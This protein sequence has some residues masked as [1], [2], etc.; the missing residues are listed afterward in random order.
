MLKP[1]H[2]L[3]EIKE[4][5]TDIESNNI[6]RLYQQRLKDIENMCLSDFVSKF[7][8][9]YKA[10]KTE[11]EAQINDHL[12]ETECIEDTPD[13]IMCSLEDVVLQHSYVLKNG[14]EIVLRKKPYILR[15]VHFDIETDSEKF[16]RELLMLFTYWR[17]KEKDLIKN[18]GSFEET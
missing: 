10:K 17:N 14:T 12:P 13:D 6:V 3:E 18:F 16:Y 5:R 2:L 4:D 9:K 7:F 15:W 11:Y 1:I 8:V